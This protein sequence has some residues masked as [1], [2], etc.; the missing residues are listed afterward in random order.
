MNIWGPGGKFLGE[1]TKDG[2]SPSTVASGCALPAGS[3][4]LIAM[5]LGFFGI[6]LIGLFLTVSAGADPEAAGSG[7]AVSLFAF[8]VALVFSLPLTIP[9]IVIGKKA[10][11]LLAAVE[12]LVVLGFVWGWLEPLFR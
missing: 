2:P 1:I 4:C 5:L 8:P 11:C 12:Y 9:T 10:G 7:F 6:A 3:G